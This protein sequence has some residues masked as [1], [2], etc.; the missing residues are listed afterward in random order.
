MEAAQVVK[1]A[2]NPLLKVIEF[3]QSKGINR[4]YSDYSEVGQIYILS[5]GAI[6]SAESTQAVRGKRWK[7]QLASYDDFAILIRRSPT[8]EAIYLSTESS[9]PAREKKLVSFLQDSNMD[10]KEQRWDTYTLFW[11]FKGNPSALNFL[12][13]LP[14]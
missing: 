14:E 4:V 13:A 2:E 9:G 10:Y 7:A 3:C 1:K 6:F 8:L 5:K 11:G 12:R